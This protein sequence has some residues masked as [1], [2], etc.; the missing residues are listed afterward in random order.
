MLTYCKIVTNFDIQPIQLKSRK[1]KQEFE[2]IFNN[3]MKKH[4]N[5][6]PNKNFVTRATEL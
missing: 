4:K 2:R 5:I 6:Y 3:L 1:N